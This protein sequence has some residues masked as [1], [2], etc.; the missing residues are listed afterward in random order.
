MTRL[1]L[2]GIDNQSKL[3]L[4]AVWFCPAACCQ[5]RKLSLPRRSAALL[6]TV[7]VAHLGPWAWLNCHAVR[8]FM[9]IIGNG[10]HRQ[11]GRLDRYAGNRAQA[12]LRLGHESLHTRHVVIEAQKVA[13]C[14]TNAGTIQCGSPASAVSTVATS[15]VM[16]AFAYIMF[17]SRC[18]APAKHRSTNDW[19]TTA[20]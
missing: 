10:S 13:G 18:S 12:W 6:Q 11:P 19:L 20:P 5:T 1:A 3:F 16:S 9:L 17:I 4:Q 2:G 8:H 7:G 15:W 14:A